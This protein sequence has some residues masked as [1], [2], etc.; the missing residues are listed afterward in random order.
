MDK[1]DLLPE[2]LNGGWEFTGENSKPEF[3]KGLVLTAV[4]Q[5]R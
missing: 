2:G 4:Y 1:S 5:G 3:I